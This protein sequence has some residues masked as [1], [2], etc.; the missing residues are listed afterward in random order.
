[1]GSVCLYSQS[2][3]QVLESLPPRPLADVLVLQYFAT[4]ETTHRLVHR[5]QFIQ[6]LEVFWADSD[7][8]SDGWLA[9]LCMMLALGCHASPAQC[10]A[11]SMRTAE[12]WTDLL[13]DAG[14]F[15][16]GQAPFF[17]SPT[18][19]TVRTICLAVIALMAETAKGVG[20]QLVFVMGFL[21]RLAMTMNLHRA[22]SLV[23]GPET[24][25]SD[26]EA[27]MRNRVW[28]TIQLLDVD[29]ATR[30]GTT[31]VVRLADHDADQPLNLSE[32]DFHQTGHGWVLDTRSHALSS[33]REERLTDS[34]FQI[35][36]SEIVP[37]LAEIVNSANSVIQPP[38]L[39]ETVK[40][41]DSRLRQKLQDAES[42]LLQ[43]DAST[44][45]SQVLAQKTIVQTQFLRV[46]VHR[47]LLA[48]HHR[49]FCAQLLKLS[50]R[51]QQQ[52]PNSV[53]AAIQSAISLLQAQ[54]DWS[55]P[56]LEQQQQAVPMTPLSSPW[57]L[58][59]C[60]DDFGAAVLY[61][62]VALARLKNRDWDGYVTLQHDEQQQQQQ[63]STFQQIPPRAAAWSVLRQSVQQH[64]RDGACRSLV[65]FKEFVGRSIALG[66]LEA[67]E[68]NGQPH[69]ML[70]TALLAVSE[71]IEQTALAGKQD[72][73]WGTA[74]AGVAGSVQAGLHTGNAPFVDF[75]FGH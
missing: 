19:T 51:T 38:L 28:V 3:N 65:H 64:L 8:A 69:M 54:H 12:E 34:T 41:L 32:S 62:M 73:L 46:L 50:S 6:E 18:L 61:L 7:R 17:A 14:Q 1:M 72:V 63:Q 47:A 35:K 27:E 70:Q 55:L 60:H 5:E 42:V 43:R 59:L 36:L 68:R 53:L 66:C 22:T 56:A 20:K 67:L 52:I 23:A 25:V 57:L 71:Q 44:A 75:Q 4:F 74:E 30:T 13:L 49:S 26:F 39:L 15:F 11:G 40:T 24:S 37:A 45:I 58:D 10:L 16:L 21:V 2:R 33:D 29:I 31:T 9:Q 48:L